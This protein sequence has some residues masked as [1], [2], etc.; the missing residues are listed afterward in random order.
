MSYWSRQRVWQW[1]DSMVWLTDAEKPTNVL[2]LL[3]L[4]ALAVAL[5]AHGGA[6]HRL[7]C[8]VDCRRADV[9]GARSVHQAHHGGPDVAQLVARGDHGAQ[10]AGVLARVLAHSARRQQQQQQQQTTPPRLRLSSR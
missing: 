1:L 7:H 9:G 2:V 3:L 6:G 5:E 8:V 10:G 4:V